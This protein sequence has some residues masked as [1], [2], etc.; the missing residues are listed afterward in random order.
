[1]TPATP[2]LR[3][4]HAGANSMPAASRWQALALAFLVA[5]PITVWADEYTEVNRLTRS[6]QLAQALARAESH[7]SAKPRDPQMR[8]MRG[9]ILSDSGRKDEAEQVFVALT[10]DYPELPE[11]YNNLAVLLAARSELD[12][13]RAALEMAIR[14]DPAYATAHENLGDVLA[15]LAARSYGKALQIEPGR[16]RIAPKIEA[17]RQL[18]NPP[19]TP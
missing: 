11:P 19:S 13:A 3:K 18:A 6:G 4:A 17:L 1:M 15:Q 8:F 12:K 16:Q 5:G 7:L 10:Q 14:N 9:V 2:L